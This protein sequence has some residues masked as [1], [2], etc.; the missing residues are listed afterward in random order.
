MHIILWII[1]AAAI[2][3]AAYSLV[4][5]MHVLPREGRLDG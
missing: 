2:A 5:S 4:E 1:V 3:R